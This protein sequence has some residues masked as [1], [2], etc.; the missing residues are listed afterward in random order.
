VPKDDF[1][2]DVLADIWARREELRTGGFAA[3]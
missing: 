3:A 1:G 2:P